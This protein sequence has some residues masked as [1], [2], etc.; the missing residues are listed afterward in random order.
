MANKNK[1]VVGVYSSR[2]AV[3]NAVSELNSSGFQH[4]DVSVLLPENLGSK[5]IATGK[6]AL[7]LPKA[8]RPVLARAR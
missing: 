2:S 7:R 6:R 1:S 8:R 5:E 3:E 4:S